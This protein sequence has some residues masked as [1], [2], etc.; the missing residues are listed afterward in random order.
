[1]ALEKKLTHHN[2]N[3]HQKYTDNRCHEVEC[4]QTSG[5]CVCRQSSLQKWIHST[6]QLQTLEADNTIATTGNHPNKS[7]FVEDQILDNGHIKYSLND[8]PTE[9]HFELIKVTAENWVQSLLSALIN[10]ETFSTSSIPLIGIDTEIEIEPQ[11]EDT[12]TLIAANG[13]QNRRVPRS[14]LLKEVK[15]RFDTNEFKDY[16]LL[17]EFLTNPSLKYIELASIRSFLMANCLLKVPLSQVSSSSKRTTKTDKFVNKK[18]RP[19][20]Y[21]VSEKIKADSKYQAKD[22]LSETVDRQEITIIRNHFYG[23]GSLSGNNDIK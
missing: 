7:T 15:K 1:M 18:R 10:E 14:Q 13:K 23:L 9:R 21:G 17:E 3:I 5:G 22:M 6:I 12:V 19:N 8:N 20:N 4:V 2:V 16:F 11:Q